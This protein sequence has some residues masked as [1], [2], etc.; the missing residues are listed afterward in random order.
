MTNTV[1]QGAFVWKFRYQAK[2]LSFFRKLRYKALGMRVGSGTLIPKL[3][4]TW[5]H[6]VQIGAECRI[7][8]LVYFKYDGIWKPGPSIVVGDR[9]FIGTGCEFNINHGI[10]VGDDGLIASGCRFV[11]HDHGFEMGVPMNR[12]S[13]TG[14]SIVIGKD[15]WI[16]CN[17]VVLKGVNIGDGA[18]VA[19]GAVVTKTIPAM[20]IWGGVPAKKIGLRT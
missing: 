8:Q 7:E 15:V 1:Q 3:L 19:A 18:I 20:E 14:Q 2:L 13:S 11:D 12:Q 9:V 5:P 4:V 16:G 10:T 6:Q 17:V